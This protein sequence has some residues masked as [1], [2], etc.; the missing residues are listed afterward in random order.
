MGGKPRLAFL[1]RYGA[2][3]HTELF[4]ALPQIIQELSRHVDIHYWSMRSDV[5][6]PDAISQ[7][8]HLHFLPFAC[9]RNRLADK[10]V[11]TCLW[12]LC[13][14]YMALRCRM[15]GCKAL[16][17]DET[18][19]LTGGLAWLF[20]GPNV[21]MTF[22]DVF[23]DIYAGQSTVGRFFARIVKACD[24]YAMR[25]MRLIYTR[26]R[27]AA[28]HLARHGVAP[29]KIHPVYDPCNFTIYHPLPADERRAARER[30][31]FSGSDVVLVHHGI[32]H[33][34]KGND[35]IIRAIAELVPEHP[36]LKYLL[37][38]DGPTMVSLRE[39][40]AELHLEK[41][42]VFTGWLKQLSDVN[43][44]LNAGDIGLAM[45]I[46]LA[47]DHFHLTGALVHSMACGLPVL[48][49]RLGGMAEVVEENQTGLLFDPADMGEFK[50]KLLELVIDQSK[51]TAM[52]RVAH[53]KAKQHFSVDTVV[54]AT[55]KPLL[56]LTLSTDQRLK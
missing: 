53:E 32:L 38:G 3:S 49:A 41:Q 37:I 55:V 44:A 2:G 8:A 34:N 12:I 25:K 43:K 31:G 35:R 18:I 52:G 40:V 54:D 29:E 10:F 28:A 30:Y 22:A 5:P 45:R 23:V 27:A 46:G 39:L 1:F 47:S 17:I 16:H 50:A 24:Y 20:F 11:K 42:V 9:R 51:R 21:A 7:N 14:P 33:P 56:A 13:V 19:P 36:E 26:T 4:H 6:P 48:A 15:M